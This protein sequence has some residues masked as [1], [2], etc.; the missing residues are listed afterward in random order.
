M[1]STSPRFPEDKP[2]SPTHRVHFHTQ[3]GSGSSSTRVHHTEDD[4]DGNWDAPRPQH[5]GATTISFRGVDNPASHSHSARSRE[6]CPVCSQR[7]G[8]DSHRTRVRAGLDGLADGRVESEYIDGLKR[9]IGCL[10]LEVNFLRE[11]IQK[12]SRHELRA[13]NLEQEQRHNL[14]LRHYMEEVDSLKERL[15]VQDLCES[16]LRR[17]N[18]AL[19]RQL[20]VA[21]EQAT[22]DSHDLRRRNARLEEQTEALQRELRQL[23]QE[24][25]ALRADSDRSRHS[26]VAHRQQ[27]SST[28]ERLESEISRLTAEN[29]HLT[30]RVQDLL[31]TLDAA[32]KSVH[33]VGPLRAEVRTLQQQLAQVQARASTDARE[34]QASQDLVARLE[35]RNSMLAA[36]ADELQQELE[37][38]RAAARRQQDHHTAVVQELDTLSTSHQRVTTE[39]EYLSTAL[40]E[41]QGKAEASDGRSARAAQQLAQANSAL[42]ETREHALSSQRTLELV[43]EENLGLRR[44]KA[45]LAKHVEQL[46]T[47]RAAKTQE[48]VDLS[49]E[50][51]GLRR[52][53]DELN[54]KMRLVEG[55]RNIRWGDLERMA[56][57]VKEFSHGLNSD[58]S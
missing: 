47:L 36:R 44:E 42:S 22:G 48:L 19:Q 9:Q 14:A 45:D 3:S 43:Q 52:Q 20:D 55:V 37:R 56:G 29:G 1:F 53:I 32:N 17:E 25:T 51:S 31:T 2:S 58:T 27:Q 33:Q 41:A 24:T 54:R 28:I 13:Q 18:N 21:Q 15:R 10:E 6:R 46:E 57:E 50:N 39:N 12:V 38:E 26:Q 8:A 5:K 16:E 7:H 49:Q 4:V 40:R 35:A 11:E 34:Q 30:A 23:R